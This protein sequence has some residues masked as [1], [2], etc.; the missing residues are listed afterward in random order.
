M[1]EEINKEDQAI[2][3]EKSLL[4]AAVPEPKVEVTAKEKEDFYKAM[5]ADKPYTATISLFG[6]R[7]S[8]K[9]R[10]LTIA[11]HGNFHR[12]ITLDQE[13]NVATKDIT[14]ATKL[15]EYRLGLSLVEYDGKPFQPDINAETFPFN[16]QDGTSFVSEKAK[17]F[18]TWQA[19]KL[20]GILT[21]FKSFEDKV[22]HMT[23]MMEDPSFWKAAV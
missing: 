15:S 14:Y 22:L 10:T 19:P 18:D 20:A 9:F 1:S 7:T 3:D 2:L 13:K 23:N 12:Q 5:L 4:S 17:V 21:A 8:A 11:E 6:G 16:E